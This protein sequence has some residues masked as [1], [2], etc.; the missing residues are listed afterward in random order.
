MATAFVWQQL[1]ELQAVRRKLIV[2]AVSTVALAVTGLVLPRERLYF[3]GAMICASG[4]T[5]AYLAKSNEAASRTIA[6]LA[7]SQA[8]ELDDDLLVEVTWQRLMDF[9]PIPDD[10]VGLSNE[11]GDRQTSRELRRRRLQQVRRGMVRA[12][13]SSH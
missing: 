12:A 4:V 11:D 1:D 13:R 10:E 2:S 7:F 8:L 3:F 9:F 6:A 5:F